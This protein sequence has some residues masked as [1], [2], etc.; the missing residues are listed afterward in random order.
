MAANVPNPGQ[1][2]DEIGSDLTALRDA[3][4]RLVNKNDYIAS[5][6][7]STFLQA[8]P[9]SMSGPDADALVATLGNHKNLSTHYNGG[10]QAAAMNY[11]ANGQP[12][13]G[14]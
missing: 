3:F 12:F 5:M 11:K 4:Y 2:L 13:W 6:G 14:G 8:A 9:F 1:Y 7:G 10:T